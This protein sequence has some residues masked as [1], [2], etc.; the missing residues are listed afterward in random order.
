M[1]AE[2]VTVSLLW[3]K[4][5]SAADMLDA[6][7]ELFESSGCRGT[8]GVYAVS[9]EVNAPMEW[10]LQ[11]SRPDSDVATVAAI[12]DVVTAVGPVI[13]VLSLDAFTERY[14]GVTVS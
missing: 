12:G 9:P 1:P 8:V 10:R 3:W 11:F 5:D 4:L 7:T 6:L 13:E 2:S 14:P